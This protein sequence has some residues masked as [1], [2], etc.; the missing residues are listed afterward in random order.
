VTREDPDIYSERASRY[1]R[2]V[3]CSPENGECHVFPDPT[4]TSSRLRKNH[5]GRAELRWLARLGQ[6]E[7]TPAG[8]S[9]SSSSKAAAVRK[10]EVEVKVERRSGSFF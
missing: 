10:A 1:I 4:P 6:E 2:I 7:N 3:T 5:F 8:C 9:K